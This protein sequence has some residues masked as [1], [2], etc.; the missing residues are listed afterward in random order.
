M[1]SEIL[2]W[3]FLLNTMDGKFIG[4][5]LSRNGFGEKNENVLNEQELRVCKLRVCKLCVA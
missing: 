3:A 1:C 4:V 5:G 2:D